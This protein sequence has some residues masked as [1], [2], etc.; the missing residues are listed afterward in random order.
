MR[1]LLGVDY[2][3][4]FGEPT[5]TPDRCMLEPTSRLL[6]V[7]ERHGARLTAFV[8][9]AY[10]ERLLTYGSA[11]RR[12][13]EA[14]ASQLRTLIDRGHDVQLHIHPHWLDSEWAGDRWIINTQRYRLHDLSDAEVAEVVPRLVS[15]LGDITGRA[16]VAYRAGGWCLQPFERLSP[17]LAEAGVRIDSTVYAEGY[18]ANPGREFDFRGSPQR[19]CWQFD[20]DPLVPDIDGT[21][22]EVPISTVRV[23]PWFYWRMVYRKLRPSTCGRSFGDGQSLGGSGSYYARK[24]TRF[25]QS[26]ASIDGARARLLGRAR[27]EQRGR[28]GQLLNVMGHPKAL[29]H[30]SLLQLDRFLARYGREFEYHTFASLAEALSSAPDR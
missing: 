23:P 28:G 20:L 18:S 6:D 19:D 11:H 14:I 7:L 25:E 4:F 3:L 8:D 1:F 10:L 13:F 12:D 30:D 29:T 27:A 22:W 2:E 5:G 26:V 24:L 15:L 16:P 21:F 17:A 9:V